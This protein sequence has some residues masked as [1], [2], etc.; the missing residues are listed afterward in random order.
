MDRLS[1][2]D[3][4]LPESLIAQRPLP[5]RAGSKLLH[6]DRRRGSI[7]HRRFRDV[8]TILERGDLLVVNN[9]RVTARRLLGNRLTGGAIEVLLLEEVSPLRFNALM[10]SAGRLPV[11]LEVH[12][13]E[14]WPKARVDEVVGDI[15]RV[16]EF[17]RDPSELIAQVGQVPLPPYIHELLPDPERYQTVF[18]SANGSAAAPTAG[19]HFTEHI[20]DALRANGVKIAEVTLNVGLDTFRPVQLENL[21]D[22]QMHGESAT[23]TTATAEAIQGCTG[24]IVAVGT[25]TVRTLES[26]ARGPRQMEVGTRRTELFIRPGC[27]FKFKVVDGMFTNF[28]LPRT[29]M[30]MMISAFAG[31]KQVLRAYRAAVREEYRFLS[32]GDSML[33]L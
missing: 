14:A 30:L 13:G 11:G 28:H 6:L 5:D 25:T 33:I 27:K 1:D 32:F 24:R 12:F 2:Y 22:H 9:T 16:V 7:T 31:R 21:D 3:Y 17:D 26:F 8:V 15:V 4:D 19:L 18:A 10:K 29:T 23:L 20:L